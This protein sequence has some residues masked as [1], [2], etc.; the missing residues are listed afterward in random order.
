MVRAFLFG[1]W[2]FP[3]TLVKARPQVKIVAFTSVF[4]AYW[5]AF[6]WMLT[7]WGMPSRV[8]AVSYIVLAALL[9]G[10]KGGLLVALVNIPVVLS[11]LK[12]LGVENTAPVIAPILTLSLAALVGRL[13]DL[14]LALETQSVRSRQAEQALQ[15]SQQYL[16]HVVQERT[17]ALAAA[18]QGLQREVAE[19][20]RTEAAL[21]DSEEQYRHLVENINDVIYATD[22]QGVLTYVSPAVEA[23]S[24]YPPAELLGQRFADYVYWE[25]RPRILQ[26]FAQRLAGHL[27]PSEYRIVT[28]AGELRWVRSSS[29]RIVQADH[30]V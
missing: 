27:E 3:T 15:A 28:R 5:L 17:A 29:R 16:E 25:D 7:T 11:L 24:G 13:T 14:S 20:Q 23:Q 26:Q 12:V 1:T 18:N 19:R 22:A 21:R 6:P 2:I 9:W 8:F 4:G 30:V 10:L